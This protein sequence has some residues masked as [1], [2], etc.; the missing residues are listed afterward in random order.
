[1]IP[2]RSSGM[3]NLLSLLMMELG[4]DD[5]NVCS[6]RV[7]ESASTG[8]VAGCGGYSTESAFCSD[9]SGTAATEFDLTCSSPEQS[10]G[11]GVMFGVLLLV[12]HEVS[13]SSMATA[14]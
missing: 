6:P 2:A 13:A 12:V 4:P 9:P 7:P 1:M 8:G 5:R 3:T 11:F 10:V 14:D